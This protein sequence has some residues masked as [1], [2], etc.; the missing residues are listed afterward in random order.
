MAVPGFLP[1]APWM[2]VFI[3]KIKNKNVHNDPD[4]M[5]NEEQIVLAIVC[6]YTWLD[7]AISFL[8]LLLLALKNKDRKITY[9]IT[10]CNKY[11][12]IQQI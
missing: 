6:L 4:S 1:S 9:V 2:L 12:A 11:S 7:N 10:Q 5:T 3:T 8:S